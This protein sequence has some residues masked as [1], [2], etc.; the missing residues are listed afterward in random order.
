ME[1][2]KITHVA[3]SGRG[4]N[5]CFMMENVDYMCCRGTVIM[6]FECRDSKEFVLMQGAE[7]MLCDGGTKNALLWRN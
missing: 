7:R 4:L 6:L 2:M 1:G 5:A 3:W